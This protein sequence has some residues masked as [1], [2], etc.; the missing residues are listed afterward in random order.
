MNNTI[1][2]LAIA[3]LFV[4]PGISGFPQEVPQDETP[5]VKPVVEENV[6][7]PIIIGIPRVA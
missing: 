1:R 2:Y 4:F 6:A 7:F 3:D 5:A